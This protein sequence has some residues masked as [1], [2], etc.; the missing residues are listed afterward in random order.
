MLKK[1][2]AL[3]ASF[4]AL[5]AASV[6]SPALAATD[7]AT[8]TATDV[9]AVTVTGSF[10]A[11]T[12]EDSA[13]P[14]EAVNLEEL[15]NQG[16]PSNIDLVKGLTEIG[17]VAGEANR[18]NAF[19]IGAASIN[20]RSLS[21]SRTVV[22]FNG[23]R[24][25]EQYSAS[26]GRFNNIALIPNA[27]IGRVEVLK[28]GGATTYGADAVGGV[29][30]YITR[31]NLDGVEMNVNYRQIKDS[32]GDWD[33]SVSAG[34]V[35]DNGNIMGVVS[36]THRS[37][38]DLGTRDWAFR[39]YFE[40]PSSWSIS[41]N[42]GA[43]DFQTQFNSAG[44][45]TP[46]T[47][48]TISPTATA[49]A[50]RYVGNRQIS[51]SSGLVRDPYCTA[52]GGFAGWSSTPSP[53]CYWQFAAAQNAVEEQDTWQAYVEANYR[54]N[55][56]LKFHGE[57][58]LYKLDIPNIPIDNGGALVGNVPMQTTGAVAGL[59][60]SQNILLTPAYFVPGTNPAVADMLA[61]L[62]NSDGTTAFTAQQ[63]ANIT[64]A[65]TPGR[66]GLLNTVW[67]PFAQGASPAG[68]DFQ[69]N[70]S[71]TLRYTVEFSGDI[72]EFW[73]NQ[74]TWSA[75]FT[76]NTLDYTIASRD[77]LIDRLQAG[78]NGLGG[79]NC[80]GTTPGANGCQYFNPFSTAVQ[81][82]QYTGAANPGYVGTG[83]YTG[84]T[85]NQGLTNSAA[86][87]NWMYV[88]VELRRTSE[89]AIFDFV[90]SG[91]TNLR[92]WA[93]NPIAVAFGGQYRS[94]HERTNLSDFAD[95]S[96]N[97]CATLGRTDCSSKT[98]PLVFNRGVQLTGLTVD[99]NR[100][101]PVVAYFG[102]IQLPIL[103]NLNV[104]LSGRYEK[105][106]SDVTPIDNSVFVGAG[107]VK[108]QAT[109][110]LALRATAGQTFTQVNPPR[111]V[112]GA[113]ANATA[114]TTYG[115]TGISFVSE[116]WPNLDVRPEKGFNYNIG[117]IIA[118]GDF[119]ATIDYYNIHINDIV[120]A[121]TTA[122]LI[123]ALAVPG[124]TGAGALINC[125]SPLL[126]ENQP[127][128]G[129]QPFITLNGACVQGTSAMNSTAGNGGLGGGRVR[130]FG[131]QGTQTALINGGT[132]DTSGIDFS[133]AYRFDD[134]FGGRLDVSTDWTYVLTY[135]ASDFVI[136]GITVGA[137]YDGI[138]SFNEATGKNGQHVAQYR[139]SITFNFNRGRHNFNLTT[140]V[141]SGFT[142]DNDFFTERNEFN[143]N[144]GN[145][146]GI[147]DVACADT[148]PVSPPVPTGV[149]TGIY[150]AVA[151]NSAVGFCAG[152]NTAI[153]TGQKIPATFNT[154]FTYRLDLP[155]QTT[156]SVTVQNV[157]DQDPIFSRDIINYDA[158]TG[159][160]LGRTIRF[161]LLKKW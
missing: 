44:V 31:R 155:W 84:Y 144:V 23:R 148:N 150:G 17:G 60:P 58:M 130:F 92:L 6:A 30:N 160:P 123:Q 54:F 39:D 156:M 133:A 93:E 116:N 94:F 43:F 126:T 125:S 64:N 85:A 139:G 14:V 76:L 103:D 79:A 138:G 137:G 109:D 73:G 37:E 153:L 45:A 136:N 1:S 72:P 106:M 107:S 158:F 143:Q 105:F 135:E 82:N 112:T 59:F 52:L 146:S 132:L 68:P 149:G 61:R 121:G 26:V 115:G 46:G 122:Q 35:G 56:Y 28:E 21:S 62:T 110:W 67:R 25:P 47:F 75:A 161:G 5:M 42:P 98:G 124:S 65:T 119:R 50:N 57:F 49:G 33:W 7:T 66:V 120:R 48:A 108:W 140:R 89:Y 81:F 142:D 99:D 154:D 29:V 117:A 134:V 19:S 128:L 53:V 114:P 147:V 2:L 118:A 3:S 91:E 102:E 8:A 36:F 40:N 152:Q 159:S 11:G 32:D 20:L 101:Y 95:R 104:Q 9:D 90:V 4:A 111:A 78:L 87:V 41:G 55:D 157:F 18:N 51:A 34:R 131:A 27:A 141:V 113:V 127:L 151:T 145:G 83:T 22:V 10:I 38:L 86:L 74:L 63:I 70:F 15:R 13:M 16:S 96:I 97:P 80:T 71:T 12:P 77:M 24:F 69:H 129:N 88:P 100:T